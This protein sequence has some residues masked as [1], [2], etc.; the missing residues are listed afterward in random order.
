MLSYANDSF[1]GTD[2][3]DIH[4]EMSM[5]HFADKKQSKD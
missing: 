5:H 1:T 3:Q 4:K 2:V